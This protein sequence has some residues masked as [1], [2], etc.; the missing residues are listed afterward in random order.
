VLQALAT[1][2]IDHTV[3]KQRTL[4]SGKV[5]TETTTLQ[6]TGA[7]IVA[8]LLGSS[9]LALFLKY[10]D[11]TDEEKAMARNLL[12][13]G[14]IGGTWLNK[15]IPST[16]PLATDE[17]RATYAACQKKLG[18]YGPLSVEQMRSCGIDV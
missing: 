15:Y 18:I 11:M 13:F 1:P 2:V 14:P 12:L 10:K 8:M 4:K 3:T 6:V 5:V 9:F 17:E 7:Q 16:T